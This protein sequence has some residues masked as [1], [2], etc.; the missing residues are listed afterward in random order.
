MIVRKCFHR[1]IA[2]VAVTGMALSILANLA[3]AATKLKNGDTVNGFIRTTSATFRYRNESVVN[4]PFETAAGE[5][6]NFSAQRGDVIRISVEPEDGSS[7]SPILVLTSSQTGNQV[8]YTD[9]SNSLQYQVPMT[10]EYRLLI[11]GRNNS[12]GRYTLSISGITEA[13]ATTQTS[14]N[15]TTDK[16]R[17]LLENEYGLRV[18]D[19]CPPAR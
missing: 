11:L 9:K 12:R 3:E 4:A 5:E 2:T 18:L 6:Y 16:R 15:Q 10:G 7:L 17:Q 13:T 14:T 1:V 8:A 19:S